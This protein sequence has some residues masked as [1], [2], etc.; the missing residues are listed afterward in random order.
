LGAVNQTKSKV[1]GNQ[2]MSIRG[3]KRPGAGRK[4]G[5]KSKLTVGRDEWHEWRRNW[6]LIWARVTKQKSK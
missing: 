6:R 4:Q 5:A 1:D 3:D 2:T